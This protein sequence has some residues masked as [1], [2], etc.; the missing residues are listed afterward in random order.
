[1]A[2]QLLHRHNDLLHL[3]ARLRLLPNRTLR[4]FSPL[5]RVRNEYEPF[6]RP[7]KRVAQP[8]QISIL[9]GRSGASTRHLAADGLRV[10]DQ[11][12]VRSV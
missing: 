8:A 4:Q 3:P 5:S 6:G 7:G 11:A 10:S 9:H 12:G 2:C 1:M